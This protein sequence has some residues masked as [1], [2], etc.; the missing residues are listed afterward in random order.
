M[1]EQEFGQVRKIRMTLR[2]PSGVIDL[3]YSDSVPENPDSQTGYY[4][5]SLG[6]YQ[7]YNERKNA[8]ERLPLKLSDAHIAEAL[9][10]KGPRLTPIALIDFLI[11][12]LQAG[13]ISFSAGAE[14]V[15]KPSL[16]DLIGFY[17]E[18]KKIL[19]SQAGLN[20][21]RALRT[22]VPAI[23]GVREIW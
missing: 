18:Q 14:S 23:G 15:T 4:I 12:G 17:K 8:W 5:A 22:P 13:A 11:M 10:E 7:K 21:G 2:D 9:Q 6:N 3:A 20:T 1:T 19:E 16:Q